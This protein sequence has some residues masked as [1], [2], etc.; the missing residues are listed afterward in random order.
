MF[1]VIA[2]PHVGG[3]PFCRLLPPEPKEEI[4]LG[5]PHVKRQMIVNRVRPGKGRSQAGIPAQLPMPVDNCPHLP[6]EHLTEKEFNLTR[7]FHV[8]ETRS[9]L[10]TSP[11]PNQLWSPSKSEADDSGRAR[12]DDNMRT[13]GSVDRVKH[14]LYQLSYSATVRL[15]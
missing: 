2:P 5:N 11:V 7:K 4:W 10:W 13:P 12:T 15:R 9:G 8:S 6:H 3:R 14:V 1:N